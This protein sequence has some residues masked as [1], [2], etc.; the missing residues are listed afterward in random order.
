V[1]LQDAGLNNPPAVAGAVAFPR[2]AWE[3]EEVYGWFVADKIRSYS[4]LPAL[5]YGFA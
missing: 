4:A 1:R 3:R 5:K 2:G